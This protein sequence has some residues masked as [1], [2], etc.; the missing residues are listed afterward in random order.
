MKKNI[1]SYGSGAKEQFIG[2]ESGLRVSQKHVSGDPETVYRLYLER[3]GCSIEICPSKGLS[4]RDTTLS[5]KQMFWDSPLPNLPDPE[6]IDLAGEMLIGG[7]SMPGTTWVAYFAAHVEMLGLRNWGMSAEDSNG[8]LLCLHGNASMIPVQEITVEISGGGCVVEGHFHIHDAN[9]SWPPPEI[10]PLFEVTKRIELMPGKDSLL[11]TDTIKN[12]SGRK[13]FPNW[14]YHVQLRPEP[15]CK[16]LIPSEQ[17]APRGGGI[18]PDDY[19]IWHPAPEPPKREERGFV[20]KGIQCNAR[21][22][23][24]SEGIETILEYPDGN[25]TRCVLP[26]SPY[27]MSWFSCGGA[28]DDE[29]L[30][31][32]GSVWLHRNWDGVGPEIGA[33]SLDHDGDVD[34]EVNVN[35]LSPGETTVLNIMI[36]PV[37]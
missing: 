13:L 26:P 28:E 15:G 12:V 7:N 23:D 19:Q 34:S 11:L 25:A 37:L 8:E 32:D 35:E 30:W 36:E 29:F 9:S 18:L 20:H 17:T 3:E 22:P 4:I 14:G 24:G 16:Y 31:P 1:I 21:F 6:K 5:G 27:L 2:E 33:S 10:P